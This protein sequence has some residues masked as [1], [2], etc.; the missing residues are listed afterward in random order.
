MYF[1]AQYK[2]GEKETFINVIDYK[3]RK[4]PFEYCI[5]YLLPFDDIL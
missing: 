5:G 2:L 4:K 1:V 3:N